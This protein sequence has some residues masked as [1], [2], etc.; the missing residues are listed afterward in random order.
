VTLA[1][2][3]GR[4]GALVG[5]AAAGLALGGLYAAGR[6][7]SGIYPEVEFPRIV[8]VA[9]ERDVPPEEAQK[10]LGRPLESALATVMGV[11]RIR[12]RAIRGAVEIG[13]QF[14]P[15]TDMWRALQMA[16]SRV[17]EARA[18]LPAG[19]EVVVERLTTTSFPV[20]TFNLS[21][22]I[23]PRRLRELGDLVLRPALSRIH[24]VGRIEVLGG[25]LREV[26]V[27]L[28]PDR[29]AALHLRPS[30]IADRLRASTVLQ[31]VGRFD[32][33]RALVT[34]MASA[35]PRALSDL[36]AIPVA[37]AA[38]GSPVPLSAVA[39]VFEG[40]E[41]RL[42][43]V[44]GPSGETVLVSVSRLPGA[45]TADLVERV[46]STA[47]DVA[48]AFPPGVRLDPV[49]DQAALVRESMRSVRDAILTGIVLCVVVIGLGLRNLRA[50]AIAA[51]A[52]PLTL[53]MTLGVAALAG[54]SL[55]LMSLGGLAVAIG[56]VI[57][58][59][60]VVVE[61]IGR[62]MDD[63]Q[64]AREA[65]VSGTRGLLAALVGTTATTVVV[66]LPLVRLEGVVGRFFT[67][68]AVTLS[69]A[70]ILSLIVAVTVVPLLA[71]H[72]P[73]RPPRARAPALGARYARLV[74]P[75]LRHPLVSVAAA[76]AL[77]AAGVLAARVVPS[78]FLP[79]MDEGAF[80]LDYFL[81][82]ATSLNETDAVARKIEAI[83]KHDPD[84]ATYSRRTGAELGP[85][86]ATQVS[87]GDMMVRLVPAARRRS[88]EEVIAD[89]R[90]QV[91]REVPEARTEFVQVLQDVLNDLAGTPRPIE[92]K[93]FGADYG[94]LRELAQKAAARV[95]DVPGLVDLY[96]GFEDESPE[97]RF[98]ID[99]A[100]AARF[101][102]T[103][104]D[105]AAD[106]EAS[107][108]GT[109]AAVFRR[110]DRPINVRVRYPDE[111]RF[112]PA[113][114]AS[115]ALAYGPAGAVPVSALAPPERAAVPTVLV[116]ENLRPVVIVTADHEGR[117]LGAVSRD[118][119]ERLRGLP[120][121]EGYRVEM[122][123]QAEGQART[124][125]DLTAV[126]GF[127]L[128]AVLVVLVAQFRYARHALLVLALVPLA[129]VGALLTLLA[130]NVPL[131]ASSLMGC[132]LLVGLVVKNGILL[133]EQFEVALDGGQPVEQ[134]VLAAGT[135]R[136]RPILMT[137]LATLAGLTPLALGIGAGAELQRPLAVAVMGGLVLSTALTLLVL[138]AFVRLAWTRRS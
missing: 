112:D 92:V 118:V 91:A 1:T 104:A 133:V 100:Q 55:N 137:T 12:S 113:R 132:V 111:V 74:R 89:V 8:V 84:I 40:A 45:S 53:A 2:L 68:L 47:R 127:G 54:Q 106:L 97:L 46:T 134:A 130:A 110:A 21:G 38:D 29:A 109:I 105:V 58:D 25:D 16:E 52:V 78:G 37:T 95:R 138:P 136:V 116:R 49:Y 69:A 80:V 102:R 9:R 131:N 103:A 44:S 93:L 99:P 79:T 35:E 123:G 27:V 51:L 98:R 32:Q 43:R 23:D 13:L 63:G 121:P 20:V 56:L 28:D 87:R 50:G 17:A 83:L 88:A 107:L 73:P 65:A 41:D 14:A 128:L 59:A 81:P 33:S 15:A 57:D 30:E 82:A 129:L 24:G 34:V 77:L 117:D 71:A 75:V 3:I 61:A 26:E 85:A 126:L 11:E 115:L 101:G 48:R 42:L 122:G 4:R 22:P 119:Q 6:L 64:P 90:A 70:V 10:S 120:L 86:A 31:A 39:R 18:E 7:P 72:L 96:P 62:R 135:L 5:L 124:F 19:A 125:A 66:L 94:V 36:E 76:V 114:V 108:R 60:I 67:A